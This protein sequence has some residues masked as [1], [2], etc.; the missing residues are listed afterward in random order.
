MGALLGG[1]TSVGGIPGWRAERAASAHEGGA[2]YAAAAPHCFFCCGLMARLRGGSLVARQGLRDEFIFRP[3]GSEDL[4]VK[5]VGAKLKL[6]LL[7]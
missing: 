7:S 5:P 6:L 4:I 3:E 2:G 1:L